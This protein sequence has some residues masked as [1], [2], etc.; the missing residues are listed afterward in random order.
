MILELA[1]LKNFDAGTYKAGVQLAGSLTTYFDDVPVSR[2]IP[3]SALV[4]GNRVILAMPGDNPKDAVV[5]ATWPGGSAGGAE[6]HGNEYH[7]PDF[8]T[9]AA[10]SIHAAATTATHGAGANHLALFGTPATLV[11]KLTPGFSS[12]N[13]WGQSGLGSSPFT[14]KINGTP[15]AT[16]VV[17]KDDTGENSLNTGSC[18]CRLVL[19]NLTRGNSRLIDKANIT[20]NTITTISST[21]NWA[22]EDNITTQSQ[23]LA[24]APGMMDLDLSQAIPSTAK[25]IL[26]QIYIYDTT[27]AGQLIRLHVYEAPYASYRSFPL[28]NKVVNIFD[29]LLCIV[30]VVSNRISFL[31]TTSGATTGYIILRYNGKVE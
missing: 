18:A 29:T 31:Y 5:I 16:S 8:A 11:S 15:T 19:Y 27:V 1:V 26:V 3:T 25:A 21:D 6:V 13:L 4:I 20:T 22:A 10:L 17:Y 24:A 7:D 12:T 9:E 30:P 2:A 14:A 23:I 28:W